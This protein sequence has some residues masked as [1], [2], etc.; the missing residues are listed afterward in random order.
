MN[1][2]LWFRALSI[3]PPRSLFPL[4]MALLRMFYFI[5]CVWLADFD[6]S[7]LLSASHWS[8]LRFLLSHAILVTSVICKLPQD[9]L[10]LEPILDLFEGVTNLAQGVLTCSITI[11]AH[12]FWAI[13]S[14]KSIQ[15]EPAIAVLAWDWIS[16][17]AHCGCHN[18]VH[19]CIKFRHLAH[20]PCQ[21]T[22]TRGRR[23]SR[24]F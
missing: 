13:R 23:T 8:F 5:L 9:R 15:S 3:F 7:G 2:G 11:L 18:N 1:K 24:E 19:I 16:T 17:N 22:K 10:C 20:I 4:L 14:S 12:L 6:M 21:H